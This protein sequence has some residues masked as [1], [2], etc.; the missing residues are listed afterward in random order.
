MKPNQ[1]E[2][3]RPRP[4][5][6]ASPDPATAAQIRTLRLAGK[7]PGWIAQHLGIPEFWV[8]GVAR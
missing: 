5:V 3:S 8:H 1:R 7:S 2:Q 6:P 4:I